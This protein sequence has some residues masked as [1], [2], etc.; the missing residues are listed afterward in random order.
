VNF[1]LTWRNASP[2]AVIGFKGSK[3][4]TS[5]SYDPFCHF[6]GI[7]DDMNWELNGAFNPGIFVA[8]GPSA[9]LKLP[10]LSIFPPGMMMTAYAVKDR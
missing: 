9:E 2:R 5:T 10:A 6:F 4:A 8:T 1:A 7:F 3:N